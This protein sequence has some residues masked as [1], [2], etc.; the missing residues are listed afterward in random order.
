MD[1]AP[2]KRE[3]FPLES[4]NGRAFGEPGPA[5]RGAGFAAT[6]G[7]WRRI[8]RGY[9]PAERWVVQLD[10]GSSCFLKVGVDQM[11]AG[12]LRDEYNLYSRLDASFLPRLAGWDDDGVAPVLALEDLSEAHWPPPWSETNV[13]MVRETLAVRATWRTSCPRSGSTRGRT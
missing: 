1:N 8:R 9:T 10:D 12:W 3:R 11:T 7:W 4:A 13:A 6:P 5:H 2:R